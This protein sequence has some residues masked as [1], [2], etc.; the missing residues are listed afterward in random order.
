[1]PLPVIPAAEFEKLYRLWADY[2][3]ISELYPHPQ[4]M[5]PTFYKLGTSALPRL[6]YYDSK[7]KALQALAA[8]FGEKGFTM[9]KATGTI[10]FK[11]K[12]VAETLGI[13][14]E[15]FLPV[16]HLLNVPVPYALM[17]NIIQGKV[18][19]VFIISFYTVEGKGPYY[20]GFNIY[21]HAAAAT[22]VTISNRQATEAKKFYEGIALLKARYN[23]LVR[24]LDYIIAL[25]STP[26]RQQI[27][28]RLTQHRITMLAEIQNIKGVNIVYDKQGGIGV[29]PLA[30]IAIIAIVGAAAWTLNTYI[31]EN[32]KVEKVN[33]ALDYNKWGAAELAKI[34]AELKAGL[35][36]PEQAAQ[37]KQAVADGIDVANG[38]IKDNSKPPS[39]LLGEMGDMVKWAAIGFGVYAIANAAGKN[40]K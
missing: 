26:S 16:P 33:A 5:A 14:V 3:S 7:P 35:I 36:T 18:Y 1:M 4:F 31:T 23:H 32:A 19:P 20:T 12:G 15:F 6:N 38:V 17:K 40:K 29:I 39:T 37:R 34:D 22:A 10:E 30:V 21:Q 24:T 28:N 25:P 9:P 27:I 2:K 13:N 8:L 11:K